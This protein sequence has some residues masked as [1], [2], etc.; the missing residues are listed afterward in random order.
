VGGEER[1]YGDFI[2]SVKKVNF[3]VLDRLREVLG[4]RR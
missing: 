4:Q 1:D 2:S 3:G